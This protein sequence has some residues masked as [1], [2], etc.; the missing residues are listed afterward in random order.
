M[1]HTR[2]LHMKSCHRQRCC[3]SSQGHEKSFALQISFSSSQPHFHTPNTHTHTC[4][5]SVC[6]LAVLLCCAFY[7]FVICICMEI[8]I[9]LL[10]QLPP[11]SS[12]SALEYS[13][14]FLCL[15]SCFLCDLSA[16]SDTYWASPECQLVCLGVLRKRDNINGKFFGTDKHKHNLRLRLKG[17]GI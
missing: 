9:L 10:S 7:Y 2:A 5:L 4:A 15:C 11:D 1:A 16:T 12:L 13:V 14:L 3:C 17:L 6:V 8:W